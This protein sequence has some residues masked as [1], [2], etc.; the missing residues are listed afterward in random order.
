[1]EGALVGA[2]VEGWGA[3]PGAVVGGIGV[4]ASSSISAAI[5]YWIMN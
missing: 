3:I 4:G 2:Y 1:M 5:Q